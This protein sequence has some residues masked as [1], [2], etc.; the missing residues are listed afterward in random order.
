MQPGL[1]AEIDLELENAGRARLAGNEG[2]AR[3]CA[4][5]AAGLAA[6]DFLA[7][8][9]VRVNGSAYEVLKILAEFSG[10]APALQTAATRLTMRVSEE[11]SL[12]TDVDLIA[13][14]RKLI[15][16]LD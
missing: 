14:A 13:E 11:F 16:G 15:G 6:R 1:Q 2:K 10:L 8:R 12:P 5:R 4:R 7:R 9:A 3:V